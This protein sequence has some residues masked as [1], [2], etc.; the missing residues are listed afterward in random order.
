MCD[1]D[2]ALS[3]HAHVLCMLRVFMFVSLYLLLMWF[4]SCLSSV[5]LQFFLLS[6]YS[7]R[8]QFSV[9]GG[10][11]F[12]GSLVT[13]RSTASASARLILWSA[14]A[15]R[16]EPTGSPFSKYLPPARAAASLLSLLASSLVSAFRATFTE[17]PLFEVCSAK[18]GPCHFVLH[19]HLSWVSEYHLRGSLHSNLDGRTLCHCHPE[20][21]EQF[22]FQ[23]F[24]PRP[25]SPGILLM[26]AEHVLTAIPC[27]VTTTVSDDKF[28]IPISED[29]WR[30]KNTRRA[31][32]ESSSRSI[33][34]SRQS[35]QAR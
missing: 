5:L 8:S 18:V 14:A 31:G 9:V 20:T 34:Q 24:C 35:R 25:I 32:R 13:C 19:Q 2:Y 3:V 22:V 21:M 29:V 30:T 17:T 4:V 27:S 28:S 11:L 33:Q 23:V 16:A 12:T 26:F 6:L 1:E 7:F 10:I 15:N